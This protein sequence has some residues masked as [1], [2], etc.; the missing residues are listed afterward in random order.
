MHKPIQQHKSASRLVQSDSLT[1]ALI[2]LAAIP[3]VAQKLG[4]VAG[5][6]DAIFLIRKNK[7]SVS[8]DIIVNS[9]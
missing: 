9:G 1:V 4:V 7:A 8:L 2:P 3:G 6:D 5:F